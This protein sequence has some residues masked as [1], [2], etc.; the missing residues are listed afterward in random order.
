MIKKSIMFLTFVIFLSTF[1]LAESINIEFPLGKNFK[2]GE[3]ITLKISIFDEQNNP[4]DGNIELTLEDAEKR[5]KIEKTIPSKK[6]VEIDLEEGGE[7][8]RFWTVTAKYQ[9]IETSEIFTIEME[10]LAE[11]EIHDNLLTITNIGNT[12]YTRTVKILI[13]DTLEIKELNLDI[14]KSIAFRLIAPEG[15]YEVK[16]TDGRTSIQ[17]SNVALTGNVVGIIDERLVGGNTLTGGIKPEDDFS[18]NYLRKN[19][20]VY[21][22]ILA[23]FGAMILLAIER[24]YRKKAKA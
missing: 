14:G 7:I 9:D 11:F 22:F 6:I 5:K 20:F 13:G 17:R 24:N 1:I 4:I 18:L 3:N 12:K 15:D 23:I 16:V 2:A 19:K 8:H 10:E 21:V